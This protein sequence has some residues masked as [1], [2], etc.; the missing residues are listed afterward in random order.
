MDL[1][2]NI[3]SNSS[4]ESLFPLDRGLRH[5]KDWLAAFWED[6]PYPFAFP[7]GAGILSKPRN[8]MN[9]DAATFCLLNKV[10]L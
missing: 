6:V 3:G 4:E 9:P 10:S 2:R 1:R 8:A 5:E 7:Y